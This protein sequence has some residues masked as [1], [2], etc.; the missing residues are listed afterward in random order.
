MNMLKMNVSQKTIVNCLA[1][2]VILLLV[3]DFIL[4]DY[5]F[6]TAKG[7]Y[8]DLL[9]WNGYGARIES[10]IFSYL[11]YYVF[12]ILFLIGLIFN[13]KYS[14]LMFVLL[15]VIYILIGPLYGVYVA[16]PLQSFVGALMTFLRG[17][18][19]GILLMNKLK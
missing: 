1:I 19:C 14:G 17:V 3:I 7:D 6:A 8:L 12:G 10:N 5:Y 9:L 4:T 13:V 15:T 2:V 18:L 16:L 11:A